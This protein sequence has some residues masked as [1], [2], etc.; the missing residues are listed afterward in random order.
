MNSS[1]SY[2]YMWLRGNKW[3]STECTSLHGGNCSECAFLEELRCC[4]H[5]VGIIVYKISFVF[6]NSDNML[7]CG[8][9]STLYVEILNPQTVK[10]IQKKPDQ[11]LQIIC[12]RFNQKSSWCQQYIFRSS[13]KYLELTCAYCHCK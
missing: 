3:V 8:H 4:Y 9:C 10:S 11:Y 12:K 7:L 5:N 2:G 1:K 13:C 6:W